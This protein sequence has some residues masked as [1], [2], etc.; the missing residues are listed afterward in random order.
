MF[1]FVYFVSSFQSCCYFLYFQKSHERKNCLRLCQW[2][3]EMKRI[4]KKSA[5]KIHRKSFSPKHFNLKLNLEY[6]Y[7]KSRSML[8][9]NIYIYSRTTISWVCCTLHIQHE[10]WSEAKSQIKMLVQMEV[11]KKKIKIYINAKKQK[12]NLLPSPDATATKSIIIIKCVA[13]TY[14]RY[15][16][17]A[18]VKKKKI[19]NSIKYM[20]EDEASKQKS[21]IR[22]KNGHNF[23]IFWMNKINFKFKVVLFSVFIILLD[24]FSL[25]FHFDCV[26]EFCVYFRFYFF[27]FWLCQRKKENEKQN[28]VWAWVLFV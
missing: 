16:E 14:T 1:E 25:L 13:H 8:Y 18:T 28:H 3:D 12:K 17:G 21:E 9:T 6:Y 2:H 22:E 19:Q 26:W 20:S 11:R 10:K 7:K 5:Q 24:F 27:Y 15:T 23:S 4:L